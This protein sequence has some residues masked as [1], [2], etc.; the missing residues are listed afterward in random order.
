G[1]T[2]FFIQPTGKAPVQQG[3]LVGVVAMVYVSCMGVGMEDAA[4]LI[5]KQR[6]THK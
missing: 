3:D 1:G 6:T 5:G 4:L 2:F